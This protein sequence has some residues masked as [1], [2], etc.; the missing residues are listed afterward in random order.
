MCIIFGMIERN[1]AC[2]HACS[3]PLRHRGERDWRTCGP[4]RRE[5][6]ERAFG[7]IPHHTTVPGTRGDLPLSLPLYLFCSPLLI[8]FPL[9]ILVVL[10]R[11]VRL[12][13]RSIPFSLPPFLFPPPLR[14]RTT[15]EVPPSPS[16]PI[17][18]FFFQTTTYISTKSF[19]RTPISARRGGTVARGKLQS[20]GIKGGSGGKRARTQR[21]GRSPSG[22]SGYWGKNHGAII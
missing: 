16:R 6:S 20:S 1:V 9:L 12:R 7:T 22:P 13:S 18:L 19:R 11:L 8:T 2:C 14:S 15:V 5:E 17:P 4:R 10:L 21:G 3:A